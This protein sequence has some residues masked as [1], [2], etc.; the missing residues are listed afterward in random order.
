MQ[1]NILVIIAIVVLLVVGGG[2]FYGGMV[3]GKSQNVM[4][5]F[6]AGDF[7][8]LRGNRTGNA[9][10]GFTSGD[11]LSK[12]ASSI[13]VQLPNNGGSKIIFYSDTTQINKTAS[14][15]ADDLATGISITAT[16]TTNAD[17]SITA[18]TIQIRPAGQK[19][20]PN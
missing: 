8:S 11:I 12:D 14:G 13:T 18:Q 7:Q 1:K 16:G 19:A 10:G 5:N 9:G 15:S 20:G 2:A 6:A 3:Y 4:P 17:G